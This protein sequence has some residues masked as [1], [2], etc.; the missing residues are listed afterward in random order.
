MG[1]QMLQLGIGTPRGAQAERLLVGV[2]LAIMGVGALP[3]TVTVSTRL[4]AVGL[5]AGRIETGLGGILV[6]V[7]SLVRVVSTVG[8]VAIFVALPAPFGVGVGALA[9]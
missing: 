9:V 6:G 5:H 7:I 8:M 1:G 2:L 3:M 4:R